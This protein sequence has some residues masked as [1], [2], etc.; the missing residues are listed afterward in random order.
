MDELD[1]TLGAHVFCI[2]GKCG[3]LAKYAVNP[4]TWQVTHL[5][6]EKGF[7]LKRARVL[8]LFAVK[9]ATPYE[10]QLFIDVEDLSIYPEFREDVVEQETPQQVE[11]RPPALAVEQEGLPYAHSVAVPVPTVRETVRQGVPDNLEVIG[12]GA[13]INGLE[14][15]IGKVDHLVVN[16]ANG[17]II[18]LIAEQG[19]LFTTKWTVPVSMVEAISERGVSIA[20]TAEVL[21]G[22]RPYE[23]R[24]D[25]DHAVTADRE[26]EHT[27]DQHGR[28]EE[29]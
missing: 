29:E 27:G 25:K 16:A 18:Y 20:A 1:L 15:Q 14:G 9:W 11:G 21:K 17:E 5:I 10:I 26:S 13:P 22:L 23:P 7:L 4:D 12:R 3:K 28:S 6:I 24:G 8:P 2:D 19:A